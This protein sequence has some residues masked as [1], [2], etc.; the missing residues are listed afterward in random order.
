MKLQGGDGAKG[1]K[2]INLPNKNTT[3]FMIKFK[4]NY[5]GFARVANTRKINFDR[6]I[7]LACDNI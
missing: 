6:A 3:R 7:F 1:L 4:L 2:V 5:F